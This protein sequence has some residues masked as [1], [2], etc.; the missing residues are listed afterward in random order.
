MNTTESNERISLI[1][2]NERRG[3]FPVYFGVHNGHDGSAFAPC[4]T[5]GDSGWAN[6]PC[7]WAATSENATKIARK[8]AMEFFGKEDYLKYVLSGE[9]ILY[10]AELCEVNTDK[11]TFQAWIGQ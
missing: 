7:G 2:M 5:G 10:Q 8:A 6:E 3:L 9:I 4:S 1:K 11:I